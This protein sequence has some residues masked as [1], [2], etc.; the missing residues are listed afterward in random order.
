[1][2]IDIAN[3]PALI[4]DK[5]RSLAIPLRTSDSIK[6]GDRGIRKIAQQRKA[7]ASETFRPSLKTW[8]VVDTDA[9]HLSMIPF[10]SSRIGLIG[11]DLIRSDRGPGKREK[12]Q[13]D[14]AFTS[15]RTESNATSQVTGKRKVRSFLP[16]L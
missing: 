16:Y 3:N 10:E 9:Q 5:N 6:V 13:H 12:G 11:R 14:V 8:D 1:M 15:E 2:D 4:N 7:Y